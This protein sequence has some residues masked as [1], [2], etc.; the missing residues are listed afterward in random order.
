MAAITIVKENNS[1]V[2]VISDE[3]WIHDEL[4]ELFKV[5]V[6]GA[7]SYSKMTH[8]RFYDKFSGKLPMG[9]LPRLME[10]CKGYDIGYDPALKNLRNHSR[11]EIIEWMDSIDFPFTPYEYQINIV[12]DFIRRRRL[13]ALADTGAGKSAVIY[14]IVRF[15]IAEALSSGKDGQILLMIPNITLRSQIITDFIDYGWEDARG[16]CEEI[17]PSK[18]K[19]SNK[20]V[21]ITTW[22]SIQNMDS[23]YFENFTAVIADEAHGVSAKKQYNILKNC[24]NAVDRIGLTGTLKNTDHHTMKVESCLG[25]SKTYVVTKQL[26]ALGQATKTK[27]F[28]TRLDYSKEDLK[29]VNKL[30]YMAQVD[31]LHLHRGRMEYICNVAT[32][33]TDK[34]ENVLLIFEKVEKG[35]KKY[36]EYLKEIGLEDRVC[37]VTGEVGIDERNEIKK[38]LE[39]KGGHIFLATWGTLSTGVNIKNLHSLMFVSSSKGRIRVLQ[40]VGRL[41]RIHSSKLYAKIFDFTDDTRKTTLGRSSFLEHAKERFKH[42]KDKKHPVNSKIT[43]FVSSSSYDLETF[44]EL[45]KESEYRRKA[46]RDREE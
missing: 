18:S 24:K 16:W 9:L 10:H 34:T 13:L 17:I 29:L 38:K 30:D 43:K 1:F 44:K 6:D 8:E 42:Y 31:F 7:N 46:K 15:L 11:E 21:V 22:Q 39:S 41:L 5:S 40:T 23:E 26:Q 19:Y 20:R 25:K 45:Y 12:V 27:V 35:V 37:V 4:Y 14:F 36:E 3:L 33:L 32:K 28:M 2:R